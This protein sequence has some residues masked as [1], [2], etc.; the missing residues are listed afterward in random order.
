MLDQLRKNDSEVMRN[1][2]SMPPVFTITAGGN[3]VKPMRN[4]IN[5]NKPVVTI[6]I[7]N[8]VTN[9]VTYGRDNPLID[10]LIKQE[11]HEVCLQISKATDTEP[12]SVEKIDTECTRNA[13][14]LQEDLRL[15][16]WLS[17]QLMEKN[18]EHFLHSQ[19]I[20]DS[21]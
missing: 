12:V 6:S 17:K 4:F 15:E 7:I 5:D 18:V 20:Q 10:Q 11:E 2:M 3:D 9:A 14:Q 1:R 16:L 8:L 19:N 21:G 13:S